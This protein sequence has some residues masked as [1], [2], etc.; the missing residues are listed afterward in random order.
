MR[1]GR[2]PPP[3][4]TNASVAPTMTRSARWAPARPSRD[5]SIGAPPGSKRS[6]KSE[7]ATSTIPHSQRSAL[8]RLQRRT[9]QREYSVCFCLFFCFLSGAIAGASGWDTP[10]NWC[11]WQREQSDWRNDT[12][13]WL[14]IIMRCF[15]S[16]LAIKDKNSYTFYSSPAPSGGPRPYCVSSS[17][18]VGAFLSHLNVLHHQTN[19]NI[20]HNLFESK[21]INSTDDLIYLKG[22]KVI[23]GTWLKVRK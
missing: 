1:R 11:C 13:K 15:L 22:G 21:N 23:K 18:T 3:L 6:L 12:G 8:W 2:S 9:S 17:F 7:A 19:F 20:K 4:W 14:S 16:S 10:M 5:A